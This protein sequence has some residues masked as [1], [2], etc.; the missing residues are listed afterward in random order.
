MK[1]GCPTCGC[2]MY[3]DV[4]PC[5]GKELLEAVKSLLAKV[6][7]TVSDNMRLEDSASD[8]SLEL[9]LIEAAIAKA[10]GMVQAKSD[11]TTAASR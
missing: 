6:N 2:E 5:A 3:S 8:I 4:G 1:R 10:E 9:V 11:E 7:R